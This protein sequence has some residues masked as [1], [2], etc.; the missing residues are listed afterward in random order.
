MFCIFQAPLP[1]RCRFGISQHTICRGQPWLQ[2][3]FEQS[4]LSQS[5]WNFL[6]VILVAGE[7]WCF[8]LPKTN[9]K[10]A[11]EN[12]WL[13]YDRF[14]LGPGLFSGAFAVSFREGN[15]SQGFC[16]VWVNHEA[17]ERNS[18]HPRTPGF[19]RKVLYQKKH[20]KLSRA[21]MKVH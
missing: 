4:S 15:T 11:P 20:N 3:Q 2:Y 17:S 12:G 10:F 9:S 6:G 18:T 21:A 7:D 16:Q 14:L 1:H 13:E 8:T 5:C 19:V